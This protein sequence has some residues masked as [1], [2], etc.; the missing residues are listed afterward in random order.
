MMQSIFLD[1]SYFFQYG[2]ETKKMA[3]HSNMPIQ[4]AREETE[5][6]V[7][8]QNKSHKGAPDLHL[9]ALSLDARQE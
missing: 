9:S 5:L 2:V 6:Y 1:T 7:T 3:Q 4:K 8:G